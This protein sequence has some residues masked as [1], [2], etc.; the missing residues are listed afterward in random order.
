MLGCG[1][2]SLGPATVTPAAVAAPSLASPQ[3]PGSAAPSL[4]SPQGPGAVVTSEIRRAADGQAYTWEQFLEY[5]PPIGKAVEVWNEAPE[6]RRAPDDMTYTK[7]EFIDKHGQHD[8]LAAFNESTPRVATEF[9]CAW[10]NSHFACHFLP[11]Q[12]SRFSAR[13][14]QPERSK[15]L[16][17]AFQSACANAESLPLPANVFYDGDICSALE[18]PG[19]VLVTAETINHVQDPNREGAL[20]V[21]FVAYND[22]TGAFTRYHPGA[23][24]RQSAAPHTMEQSSRAFSLGIALQRGVGAALHALVPAA[25]HGATAVTEHL[26]I[27]K[28]LREIHPLDA[29]LISSGRLRGAMEAALKA[30]GADAVDW[31]NGGIKQGYPWWVFMAGPGRMEKFKAMLG[32]GVVSVFVVKRDDSSDRPFLRVTTAG[33]KQH[34]VRLASSGKISIKIIA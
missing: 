23:S 22:T 24:G 31:S 4:A 34:A 20:R 3:G 29:K 30:A 7:Q 2:M 26:C 1:K 33:N 28:D 10:A 13:Q 6:V 5:Y 18:C 27:E 11:E 15:S 9:S 25:A 16:R 12:E 14:E 32:E 8:G 17:D 21:D 19:A